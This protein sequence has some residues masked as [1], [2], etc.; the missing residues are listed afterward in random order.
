MSNSTERPHPVIVMSM[1]RSGTTAFAAAYRAC[2]VDLGARPIRA[3]A[4]VGGQG[5]QE[6]ADVIAIHSTLLLAPSSG[7]KDVVATSFRP[8]W[9]SLAARLGRRDFSNAVN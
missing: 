4:D 5:S 7:S 6:Y 8:T 9:A 3:Q 1:H 2:G